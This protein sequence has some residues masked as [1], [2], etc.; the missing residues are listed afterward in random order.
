MA[1]RRAG[2]L[3]TARWR[4]LIVGMAAGC[5]LGGLL[6]LV[7]PPYYTAESSLVA[8]KAVVEGDKSSALSALS[9]LAG[10]D[11]TSKE[12]TPFDRLQIVLR[13]AGFAKSLLDDET[14]RS[15]LFPHRWDARAKRWDEPRG[16]VA[17][18]ERLV[19]LEGTA[20]P[21]ENTALAALNRHLHISPDAS[22]GV[23]QI[24]F[25]AE[26]RDA[27][28][29]ML[30]LTIRRADGIV[31]RDYLQVAQSYSKYISDQLNNITNVPSRQVLM[32]Q[33]DKYQET[34]VMASVGLPFA[35]LAI[36]PPHVPTSR[37]GPSVPMYS[38]LGIPLGALVALMFSLFFPQWSWKVGQTR[39]DL[40][41]RRTAKSLS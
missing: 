25:T 33:W 39:S 36:D 41:L 22:N 23:V 31:R 2:R 5:F 15:V 1:L 30:K 40:P 10:S 18:I 12:L 37:S 21:D 20:E 3:V 38:L 9:S 11:N 27:A 6:A 17:A 7:L 13:S 14:A 19:G 29:Y 28:L 4:S 8:S 16:P 26:T 32:D 24:A 34:V 35:E